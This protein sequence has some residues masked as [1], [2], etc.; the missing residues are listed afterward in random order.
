MGELLHKLGIDWKLLLAQA[1]NFFIILTVLRFTVYKPLL[2]MLSERRER[3]RKGLHEAELAGKRLGEVEVIAQS[4]LAETDKQSLALFAKAEVDAKKREEVLLRA[5]KQK[6]EEL[7]KTA[8]KLAA[9]KGMDAEKKI[10]AE[11]A[12]LVR[13]AIVKTVELDPRHVD[14]SL[15]KK[16]LETVRTMPR[17]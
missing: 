7:L 10:H 15:I 16:A 11:A 3:I 6:E 5:A 4:K 17:S 8:E 13:A 9:A 12:A 1:V 2:R 14:E